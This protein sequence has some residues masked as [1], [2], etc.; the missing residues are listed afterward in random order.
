ML[1]KIVGDAQVIAVICNQWGDSGK[2]K[3]SDYFAQHWADIIARGTGGN[4]AGHTSVINGQ[5]RIFHLIPAGIFY[6]SIGKINVLGNGMVID[7]EVL[8]KELS[9]LDAEGL[10]YDNLI[11]S[12]EAHVIMP[13]EIAKDRAKNVSLKKGSIGSTGRGIGP[14]YT[15]K[16]ARF[17]VMI[18]DLYD[19]DSL[20]KKLNKAQDEY[21]EIEI[22]IDETIAYLKPFAEKIKPFVRNTYIE[23]QRFVRD[24]KKILVEGAQGLLLSIEHGTN[25]FV[26]SSDA[27][28]H[29]TLSGVGLSGA[30]LVF[31]IVKFP[32]MT[33][34]GGGPFPT[35]IGGADSE[36]YCAKG[37]D[38]DVFYETSHYLNAPIDLVRIRSLQKK[39]GIEGLSTSEREELVGYEKQTIDYI[40]SH[41]EEVVGLINSN[42]LLTRGVGIRLAAFEYGA[43]TKRPRRI[44]W[45]DAV[46]AK[47]AVGING[48]L[49]ILTKPDSVG[50][51]DE[52]SLCYGYE[53]DGTV[54]ENFD[55]DPKVLYNVKPVNTPYQG[56][57][58]ISDVRMYDKLPDSLTKAIN[59]FEKFTNGHVAIVSVGPEAE[60]TIIR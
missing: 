55:R 59:E 56:Y 3:F 9:A 18:R 43:T 14:T 13:H 45:T 8:C 7:P 27:S 44:G 34:V 4:N 32:F 52:F 1:E 19:Q 53:T 2:G 50:G 51:L 57:G 10:T 58:D 41:R 30:D 48:P 20:V 38:H 42:D 46:A 35:E 28:R 6:D 22:D 16:T 36:A 15:D 47:Y 49:M 23:M 26:T 33:R 37:L 24:G 31:G 40:K 25:P 5:E 11:I 21:P 12:K 17:G 39:D 54:T 29:G 60:Q